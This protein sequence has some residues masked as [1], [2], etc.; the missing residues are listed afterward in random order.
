[1]G[2]YEQL[3]QAVSDVIKTNGNQEITGAIM[4]N[5]LL[6]IIST[7][8]DNATFAGIAT[9]TTNPGTPDQNVFYIA[10]EPGVYSNF[11]G[12]ELTD[13]VFI[14]TNK[15]G[16]WV[17][18]DCG[19]ATSAKVSELENYVNTL[20][21]NISQLY[22]TDGYTNG[23]ASG[24]NQYSIDE[25][26]QL[27]RD[28]GM[29]SVLET[30]QGIIFVNKESKKWELWIYTKYTKAGDNCYGS[31]NFERVLSYSD[32]TALLNEINA[33]R[34]TFEKTNVLNVQSLNLI[35][36]LEYKT[37]NTDT[38]AFGDEGSSTVPLVVLNMVGIKTTDIYFYNHQ[39]KFNPNLNKVYCFDEYGNF[40]RNGGFQFDSTT[41]DA[42]VR[43]FNIPANVSKLVAQ[44]ISI[45]SAFTQRLENYLPYGVTEREFNI[46]NS[47]FY[48]LGKTL[49]SVSIDISYMF[50][51]LKKEIFLKAGNTYKIT[52]DYSHTYSYIDVKGNF[53]PITLGKK[54]TPEYDVYYIL[55]AFMNTQ[56][57]TAS[58]NIEYITPDEA[59]IE[60]IKGLKNSKV[61]KLPFTMRV[62]SQKG[63]IN[64]K[65]GD[66]TYSEDGTEYISEYVPIIPTPM[67]YVTSYIMAICFYDINKNF[68][69]NGTVI[70]RSIA[71]KSP[72]G[73]YYM[74]CSRPSESAI[75]FGYVST[76]EEFNVLG[77][78]TII[79][80]C[81]GDKTR[82]SVPNTRLRN[83]T[84]YVVGD[85][86]AARF[87]KAFSPLDS[88]QYCA[89]SSFGGHS[90][91]MIS[92][93]IGLVTTGGD[94]QMTSLKNAKVI[95]QSS[96]N[97]ADIPRLRAYILE[98][99]RAI[100]NYGASEIWGMSLCAGVNTT[101]EELQ[102]NGKYLMQKILFGGHF[103]DHMAA[104]YQMGLYYNM[105]HPKA[106]IQPE[107][108]G[109]VD[110]YFDDVQ[111]FI[112]F[113]NNPIFGV[114]LEFY[115]QY[116]DE[117]YDIYTVVSIDKENNK[118][119]ATLKTNS[120]DILP[121]ATAGQ[122]EE[123]VSTSV[124]S[125][126]KSTKGFIYNEAD[127][128][129]V[130]QGKLPYNI[131]QDHTVHYGL[132]LSAIIKDM[133]YATGALEYEDEFAVSY[134]N[135][136]VE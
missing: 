134:L 128:T 119:T 103:V 58:I 75:D 116:Y 63:T 132:I 109:N 133:L 72:E 115:M 51:T 136:F 120:S 74:V 125:G 1:M 114:G 2:N 108:G 38:G 34:H 55:G 99:I 39:G 64:P 22:P 29:D 6:T 7:V 98:L 80:L 88:L 28:K 3:K 135:K 12:V 71:Y 82:L 78:Q 60:D 31:Y 104:V 21:I 68:I 10:S 86:E 95:V 111:P 32:Y 17:K 57:R 129:N 118:I 41:S 5:A 35:E 121:G 42:N 15:N 127:K 96:T 8:G 84:V 91:D 40:I 92:S 52:S 69:S 112:D 117:K 11:G 81:R 106:F 37:F 46:R 79:N 27:L 110:I 73:A 123:K 18:K 93:N 113:T 89:A 4:Q 54:F 43:H 20:Y 90:D 130:E 50:S 100:R 107:V 53:V 70:Q 56:N 97:G 24:G 26:I 66:V 25:A 44:Y 16:N 23:G 124:W 65:N 105:Y 131:Y 33:P 94:L 59:I 87:R 30:L 45:E 122:Y 77:Q 19:I 83:K 9:P 14:F 76:E 36:K 85:S 101:F 61:G 49:D 62:N 48:L 126:R 102:N 13:Q 67:I 47:D